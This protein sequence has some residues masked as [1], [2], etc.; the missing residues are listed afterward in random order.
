MSDKKHKKPKNVE[1]LGSMH[2]YVYIKK[3][4]CNKYIYNELL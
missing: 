1:V 2:A 4:I 3:I